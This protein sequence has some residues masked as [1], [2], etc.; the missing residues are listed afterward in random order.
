MTRAHLMMALAGF[1]GLSYMVKAT[2][3][4]AFAAGRLAVETVA[5]I[6]F[7]AVGS[8]IGAIGDSATKTAEW[9]FQQEQALARKNGDGAAP[10][11]IN[12]TLM[13]DG[14]ELEGA[15]AVASIAQ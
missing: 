2:N 4:D 11:N 6:G 9:E 10:S 3:G 14:K 7:N 1:I 12:V 5:G 13:V 8:A 15:K